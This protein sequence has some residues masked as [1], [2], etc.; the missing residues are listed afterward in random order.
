MAAGFDFVARGCRREEHCAE[1]G[2]GG[3]GRDHGRV[4]PSRLNGI[5]AT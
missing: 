2:E 3:Q 5:I 4:R 1:A